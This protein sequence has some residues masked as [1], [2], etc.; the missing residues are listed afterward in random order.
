MHLRLHDRFFFGLQ[1]CGIG[2]PRRIQSNLPGKIFRNSNLTRQDYPNPARAEKSIKTILGIPE[3]KY[4]LQVISNRNYWR[5]H[6]SS[7][8]KRTSTNFP[9][10]KSKC[11]KILPEIQCCHRFFFRRGETE[12][13]D[14]LGSLRPLTSSCS[15]VSRQIGI[16]GHRGR[17]PVEASRTVARRPLSPEELCPP[18]RIAWQR[19][20]LGT[21]R[22]T[23]WCCHR[24]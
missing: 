15:A 11:P 18:R 13:H 2:D 19:P 23:G 22:R 16:T 8:K 24:V 10:A 1:H 6:V 4:E 5:L 14:D 21:P 3:R 7:E 9:P 17:D 12:A 20:A